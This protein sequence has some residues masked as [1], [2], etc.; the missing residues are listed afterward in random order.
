MFSS[1]GGGELAVPEKGQANYTVKWGSYELLINKPEQRLEED[2]GLKEVNNSKSNPGK[3]YS[4]Q[5]K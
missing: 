4:R 2:Q 5:K 3:E 1:A